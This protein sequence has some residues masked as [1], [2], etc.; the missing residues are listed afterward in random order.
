[1]P[2]YLSLKKVFTQAFF[3]KAYV[4]PIDHAVFDQTF[5]AKV[6]AQAFF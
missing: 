3:E 1:L 6:F 4:T 2:G 5:S